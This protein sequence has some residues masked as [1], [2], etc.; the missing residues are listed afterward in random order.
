MKA[1]PKFGKVIAAMML[2]GLWVSSVNAQS[3]AGVETPKVKYNDVPLT[4]TMREE[5][6]MK[7]RVSFANPAN[8]RTLIK[9]KNESGETIYEELVWSDYLK[10]LDFNSLQDG[11]YTLEVAKGSER[12]NKMLEIKTNRTALLAKLK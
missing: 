10:K 9:V 8:I 12:F 5:G 11:T 3:V 7:F 4:V 1:N 2:A 6:A